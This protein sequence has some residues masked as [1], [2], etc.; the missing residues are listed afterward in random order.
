MYNNFRCESTR[1]EC[2]CFLFNF[3]I[4]S[5]NIVLQGFLSQ[6]LS[7]LP[8]SVWLIQLGLFITVFIPNFKKMMYY[9]FIWL[10]W[11]SVLAHGIFNLHCGMQTLSCGMWEL[12]PQP[13]TEPR[14]L[15]LGAWSL[16]HWT[17]REALHSILSSYD[18]LALNF[19]SYNV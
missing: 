14:S 5:Q 1:F 16:T 9:L 17:T 10:R 15:A 6:L 2:K 3:M 4:S 13:G 18:I 19:F 7:S 8:P 12:V 11:V